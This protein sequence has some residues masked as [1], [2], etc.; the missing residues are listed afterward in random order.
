MIF[1]PILDTISQKNGFSNLVETNQIYT[2]SKFI[3]NL[4][5]KLLLYFLL[6]KYFEKLKKGIFS[7]SRFIFKV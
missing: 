7:A 2:K 4:Y 5:E 6:R 3:R 1:V